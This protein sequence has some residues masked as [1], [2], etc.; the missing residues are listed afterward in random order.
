MDID[1][2]MD[3]GNGMKQILILSLT[4]PFVSG[5][6]SQMVEHDANESCAKQDKKAF[7]FDAKQSGIPLFIESASAMVL[8]VGPDDITHLPT[9]FGADAVSASNFHGAGIVS[10]MPGSVADKAG[11]KPNDIVYEFA[12]RAI[13]RATDLRVAVDSMSQGDQAS[14]KLR[15]NGG[16]DATVTAHF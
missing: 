8:C 9:I 16:K 5:C 14:I 6:A 15:R 13:D 12:G 3:Q 10:V 7:L 4:V 11:V 1:P 2:S